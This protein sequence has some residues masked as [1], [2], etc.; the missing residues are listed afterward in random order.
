MRSSYPR[1][2]GALTLA[3]GVYTLARPDSLRQAAQLEDAPGT[4]V[5]ARSIGVRDSL[6]G[7]SLIFAPSG[8]ALRAAVVARVAADASDVVAFGIA[9][10]PSVRRKAMAI[11]GAWATV[12]L[13]AYPL[14]GTP[15]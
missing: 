5:L 12:C 15:A 11:A 2:I 10:P 9:A 14:A 7:L 1:I 8:S 3:Y 13:A 4:A 6:S